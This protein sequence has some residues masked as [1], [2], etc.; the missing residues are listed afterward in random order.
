MSDQG[1]NSHN[2]AQV[3]GPL[4]FHCLKCKTVVGDSF[5]LVC[6]SEEAKTITLSAAS[7]IQRT[8]E[9][10]TSYETLDEGS[11]YFSL[12]C[13]GCQQSLGRYY[14]TTSIDLDYARTRFTFAIDSITSYE[15]GKAQHGQIPEATILSYP[16]AEEVSN[17]EP[18]QAD[19]V[20][21]DVLQVAADVEQMDA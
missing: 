11:T 5:S 12:L 3:S 20:A 17:N 4:V 9:L 10:Y 1:E 15:L 6:S 2:D 13:V 8:N 14:V 16:V 19:A 21:E 18:N 7:N